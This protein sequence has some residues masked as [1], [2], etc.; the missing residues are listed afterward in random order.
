[1]LNE[2]KASS[3]LVFIQLVQCYIMLGFR[4]FRN[5]GLAPRNQ[6]IFPTINIIIL[7]FLG[8]HNADA[9]EIGF[10]NHLDQSR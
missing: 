9:I 8:I 3:E 1:M 2:H 10:A 6:I 7:F 5:E 4:Y